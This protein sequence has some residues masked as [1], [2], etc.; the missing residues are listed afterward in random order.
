MKLQGPLKFVKWPYEGKLWLWV[1]KCSVKPY[2]LH[3][4]LFHYQLY[5]CNSSIQHVITNQGLPRF[6]VSW[7]P[8]FVLDHPL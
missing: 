1:S 2:A 8:N 7:S 5:S 6:E 4:R 3:R